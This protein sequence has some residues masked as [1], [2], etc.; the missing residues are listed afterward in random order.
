MISR[1]NS[2][3]YD[4]H[5][6]LR[7][8]VAPGTRG[9]RDTLLTSLRE[10]VRS[11]RLAPG[12]RLPPSRAL[13]TDLGVARNTVA[14]VYSELVAEGW[15]A[16]RQ[17]SGTWVVNQSHTPSTPRPRGAPP[18]PRHN[19]LPGS[20]DVAEFPRA[21]WIA[22]TRRALNNAPTEALRMGDPRGRVELRRALA[23]Y[24]ARARGAR[25][26]PE[27]VVITAGT[28]H[29][30]QIL[31]RMFGP[32]ARIA[33]EAYGLFLFRD[34]IAE[35]GGSTTPLGFDEMGVAVTD[36]DSLSTPAVLVTPAHHFP[37]GVP[38]HPTRRTA[39][40]D[41]AHR[42]GGYVLEDD[43]DGEF[44]Y[45]R[46]PIGALQSLAPERVVY[47]G[48]AS[49][50]LSPV[51]RLGWMVLPADLVDPAVAAAGGEQWMV[52]GITQLTMADFIATANYDKH[53][54]RMRT[55]YRR[56][57]DAL[58]SRL[59]PFEPAVTVSGLSAGLHLLLLLPDGAEAEMLRR[60]GEAGVGIASLSRL[61]HPLADNDVPRPD[62]VV[63]NFGTPA[64]HAFPSAVDAL[65]DV[66]AQTIH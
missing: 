34:C 66:L 57:R 53:I 17:G 9:V 35:A 27:N 43:Y 38:L 4:L 58:V 22:S 40:V 15:L 10:A 28:R 20:P 37:H 42:S 12:T 32:A 41:W 63:V 61:R 3:G 7:E 11:G 60:A 30:L 13:A 31:T 36:L 29:S 1:A 56:R 65:C 44:R 8:A 55:E 23:E 49:K 45:D 39:I 54:R 50:S 18:T 47:L 46:Q 14:E 21:A 24:L 59:A 52:N 19:L 2:A 6:D 51:L 33:V 16:S 62:G 64:Q 48:S 26:S 25:V 5:L